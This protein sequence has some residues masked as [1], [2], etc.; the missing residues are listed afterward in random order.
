MQDGTGLRFAP[1]LANQPG[2]YNMLLIGTLEYYGIQ[3]IQPF[4]V[5]VKACEADLVVNPAQ[6]TLNS[7]S[8]MWGSEA[9]FYDISSTI[10]AFSQTPACNYDIAVTIKYEDIEF[11][12]GVI[13]T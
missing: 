3:A 11:Y 2:I 10:S 13:F 8:K 7:W 5:A 12:P 9:F 6:A 4:Q 1:T